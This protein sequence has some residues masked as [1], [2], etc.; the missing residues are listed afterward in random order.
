MRKI[1]DL[2]LIA[3][4]ASAASSIQILLCVIG[5]ALRLAGVKWVPWVSHNAGYF[6]VGAAGTL[7]L[8][9]ALMVYARNIALDMS[10]KIDPAGATAPVSS[11][12]TAD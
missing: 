2:V 8:C 10:P 6:A 11:E 5:F 12:Q 9:Y 7:S 1:K 4:L 3:Y